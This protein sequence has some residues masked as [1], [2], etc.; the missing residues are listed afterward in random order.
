MKYE[1]GVGATGTG[2]DALLQEVTTINNKRKSCPTIVVISLHSP[3]VPVHGFAW[4]EFTL[5][6]VGQA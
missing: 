1:L 5:L 2:R 3:V 6:S 4:P